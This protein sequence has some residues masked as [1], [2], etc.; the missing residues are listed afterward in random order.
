MGRTAAGVRGLRLGDGDDAVIEL[1]IPDQELVLVATEK[2]L[3][4]AHGRRR[5]YSSKAWRAGHHRHPDFGTQRARGGCA[6]GRRR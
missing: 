2:R 3:R 4:E 6:A 1:C 5:F